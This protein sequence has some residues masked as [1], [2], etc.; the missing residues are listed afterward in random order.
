MGGNNDWLHGKGGREG[1]REVRG[2]NDWL[3]REGRGERGR[4]RGE[5]EQ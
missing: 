1:G 5:R 3:R 2:N 4:P